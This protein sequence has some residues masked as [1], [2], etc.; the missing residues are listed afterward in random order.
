MKNHKLNRRRFIR[1]ASA[2]IVGAGILGAKAPS[3]GAQDPE[4]EFPKITSYRT[5]GRTN[6]QVSD[7]GTGYPFSESTLKA[8]LGC[9]VNMIETSEMYG[10]GKNEMLIGNVIRDYEREKLFIVTK[11]AYSVKEYDSTQDIIDRAN[12]SLKRLQTD[13]VD[14]F[15]IH[16][17]ENSARVKNKHYHKAVDQLKKEGKIRFTGI[18]CHGHSWWDNPEETFEQVLMTAVEDGRFDIIML[19]YNFFEPE[20]GNRVL[21]ACHDKNIGTM[22]MKSVPTLIYEL[23]SEMKQKAEEE[24]GELSERYKIGY[25]KYKLQNEQA[26]AFFARYGIS[27]AE[28]MKDGAIQFILSNKNANTIC[29]LLQNFE[30]IKRYIRL[31]GTRLEPQTSEMLG[32]FRSNYSRLHCRIGCN[33]CEAACPHHL[34]VNTILRYDYYFQAKKQEKLAIQSYSELPG[35]KAD[36][37]INCAGFCEKACPHGVLAKPLLAAAHRNLSLETHNFA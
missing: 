16:S 26:E 29:T 6:F 34:P 19:P 5:L 25:E 24:G 17:A 27:G 12:A 4:E 22:I 35:K 10:R 32:L 18:S 14:C 1:N 15:M 20:M 31:S 13:Y 7:I 9:G 8:T 33:I 2:G 36:V 23:F 21:Q 37:C 11:L 3:A 30:D 28:K